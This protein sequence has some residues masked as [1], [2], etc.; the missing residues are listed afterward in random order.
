[1]IARIEII[2]MQNSFDAQLKEHSNAATQ[3]QDLLREQNK[4]LATFRMER[5][6]S[7]V[8]RAQHLQQIHELQEHIQEKERQLMELQEQGKGENKSEGEVMR[9]T[10]ENGGKQNDPFGGSDDIEFAVTKSQGPRKNPQT[11]FSVYDPSLIEHSE[12][13]LLLSTLSTVRRS[14]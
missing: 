10:Q 7:E 6:H 12:A 1:M 13:V 5:D 3:L 14:C 8:E 9:G 11:E 4:E 2:E